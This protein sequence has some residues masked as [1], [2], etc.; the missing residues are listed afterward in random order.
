[1]DITNPESFA[2]EVIRRESNGDIQPYWPTVTKASELVEL[3]KA[4]S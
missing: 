1:M 3:G 2:R 4:G